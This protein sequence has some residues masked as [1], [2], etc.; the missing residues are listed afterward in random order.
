[1]QGCA[2]S[3]R[4]CPLGSEIWELNFRNLSARAWGLLEVAL[5]MGTSPRPTRREPLQRPFGQ[6]AAQPRPAAFVFIESGREVDGLPDIEVSP[7]ARMQ[8][9]DRQAQGRRCDACAERSAAMTRGQP[10]RATPKMLGAPQG[11]RRSNQAAFRVVRRRKCSGLA[12][13]L[14]AHAVCTV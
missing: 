4:G 14:S 11:A 10:S 8:S 3:G 9:K 6:C 12:S 2:S 7:S 13:I 5:R 1:M